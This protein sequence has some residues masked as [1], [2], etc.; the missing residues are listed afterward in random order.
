MTAAARR[1]AAT[2][3]R[4]HPTALVE[5]G[6]EIGAGTS[7]WDNVHLR[8]PSVI[9]ADC[10][11]GEKTYVAYGVRIGDR[12]KIN[13]QVYVCTDV[14]IEDAVMIAA[15]VVF[16]NDRYPRAFDPDGAMATSAP[17][18][19]TRG[20]TVRTGASV[21]ARA[22]IG[23][24]IEIGAYAMVGMGAVVT[25]DVP[26]YAL[27]LGVPARVVGYVCHCGIPVVRCSAGAA[28]AADVACDRC[29]RAYRLQVTAQGPRFGPRD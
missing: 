25:A 2:P 14:V 12:V 20:A 13:A 10:I 4:L 19:D 3:P 22:V 21:G 16:T 15:G 23:S 29:G 6:V 17:T 5:D 11:V 1:A 7:I 26:P 18:D 27:V 9:G 28:K 24:G 8:G